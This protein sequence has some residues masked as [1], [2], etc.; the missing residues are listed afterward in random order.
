MQAV[1]NPLSRQRVRQ[2]G[3]GIKVLRIRLGQN[4][5]AG[6]EILIKVSEQFGQAAVADL[7]KYWGLGEEFKIGAHR[8][9]LNITFMSV[10]GRRQFSS[11]IFPV[12]HPGSW[13]P[14]HLY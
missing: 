9:W 4:D 5:F 10:P 13:T 8:D 2:I 1:R 7:A 14:R 3:K 11:T 6:F 12:A